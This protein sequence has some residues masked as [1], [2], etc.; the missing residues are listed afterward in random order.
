[1][2]YAT[3]GGQY[4]DTLRKYMLT[5]FTKATGVTVQTPS[6]PGEFVPK[7]QAQ[8]ASGQVTWSITDPGE[9][10]AMVMAQKNLLTKI[11]PD[12]KSFLI[13]H[14]GQDE[15]TD[16]G[17]SIAAYSDVIVCNPD[18]VQKCP[19]NVQQFWDTKNYPGR[20]A[21][22]ADGWDDNLAYGLEAA[23]VPR[24][25]VFSNMD[26]QKA[27]QSLDKIKPA[28][29]VWWKT[30]DQSQQIIRDKEVGMAI[31]WDGR[32]YQVKDQG[33]KQL[34][35]SHDGMVLSRELLVVPKDAPNK[36][37]AYAFM[38]WYATHPKDEAGWVADMG[39]GVANKKVFDYM[40][41]QD[42]AKIATEPANLKVTVPLDAQWVVA[43][44]D[45]LVPQFTNWLGQ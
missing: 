12:L 19:T 4:T 22:Y 20:R 16:Y 25:Q 28:I 9:D 18:I 23:G 33:M 10:D 7:L 1:M 39:Y 36:N 8:A 32:A 29:D 5:P 40:S 35:I 41:K 26:V 6:A 31:M 34:Q 24:D 38:R 30:G 11:P 17:P 21:M 37:A 13:A 2:T 3:W 44:R 27:F 42:A 14:L 45:K 15:V 43:N